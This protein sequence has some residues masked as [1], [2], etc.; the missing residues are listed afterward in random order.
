MAPKKDTAVTATRARLSR[1]AKDKPKESP[2]P[3]PKA[4]PKAIKKT[5]GRPKKSIPTKISTPEVGS[6]SDAKGKG[7]GRGKG[8][9]KE[10]DVAITEVP[11]DS[12]FN[13]E[14]IHQEASYPNPFSTGSY[15]RN[16]AALL[17]QWDS[18]KSPVNV[19]PESRKQ[20]VSE[21]PKSK[22]QRSAKYKHDKAHSA[23]EKGHIFILPPA[24]KDMGEQTSQL[25]DANKQNRLNSLVGRF[26]DPTY[27]RASISDGTDHSPRFR[28]A[29]GFRYSPG[30]G[31]PRGFNAS[32]TYQF[33]FNP[34]RSTSAI[35][36]AEVLVPSKP[37][38]SVDLT[39]SNA[40]AGPSSRGDGVATGLSSTRPASIGGPPT[41]SADHNPEY[42]HQFSTEQKNFMD[43]NP[44]RLG[45]FGQ[46]YK[47]FEPRALPPWGQQG[48]FLPGNPQYQNPEGRQAWYNNWNAS[49]QNL[50]WIQGYSSDPTSGYSSIPSYPPM[51]EFGSFPA[52]HD[53]QAPS[54]SAQTGQS[55]AEGNA[56]ATTNLEAQGIRESRMTREKTIFVPGGKIVKTST[57]I[58]TPTDEN[59]KKKGKHVE[60]PP[61]DKI[62]IVVVDKEGNVDVESGDWLEGFNRIEGWEVEALLGQHKRWRPHRN[63]AVDTRKGITKK[64]STQKKSTAPSIMPTSPQLPQLMSPELA[65]PK[66]PTT[67]APSP[68]LDFIPFDFPPSQNTTPTRTRATRI[69]KANPNSAKQKNS[70]KT[71][72]KTPALKPKAGAGKVTKSTS[73]PTRSLR[74]STSPSKTTASETKTDNKSKTSKSKPN[75]ATSKSKSASAKATA[76]KQS[77]ITPPQSQSQSQAESQP[78]PETSLEN[79]T[80]KIPSPESSGSTSNPNPTPP[81]KPPSN[82]PSNTHTP[83]PNPLP[84]QSHTSPTISNPISNSNPTPNP[85][86][87]IQEFPPNTTELK[88]QIQECQSLANQAAENMDRLRGKG[89]AKSAKNFEELMKF[90]EAGWVELERRAEEGV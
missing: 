21:M 57:T 78:I 14:I 68:T 70:P 73:A 4:T 50:P 2:E 65:H 11:T 71:K 23:S 45:A 42:Y 85:K 63:R 9:G 34:R 1:A 83:N 84:Q 61:E 56:T 19:S 31:G 79:S 37:F 25:F 62:G 17:S 8:K 90:V 66:P 29:M 59:K 55:S 89:A 53:Y 3:I 75:S 26:P 39:N 58:F 60:K 16:T 86:P 64:P 7:K 20:L 81:P 40:D 52:H 36:G 10:T 12:A 13:N 22:P 41:Y 69:S 87:S 54:H 18:T 67:T 28:S 27:P 43:F 77:K 44:N 33:G 24:S 51:P 74:S 38:K 80:T 47:W 46:N 5:P 32:P 6:A 72:S 76:A 49:Q 30:F 82:N 48:T 88:Q 35:P 15:R